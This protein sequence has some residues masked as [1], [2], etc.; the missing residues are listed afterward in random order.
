MDTKF[1]EKI[2]KKEIKKKIAISID[3][4]LYLSLREIASKSKVSF[5]YL[6]NHLL[7]HILFEESNKRGGGKIK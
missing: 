2:P 4:R 5:S 1:K 6:C 3:N 7:N